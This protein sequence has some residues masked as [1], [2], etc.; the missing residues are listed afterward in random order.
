MP[1]ILILQIQV[2]LVNALASCFLTYLKSNVYLLLINL[3]NLI[4]HYN[5]SGYKKADDKCFNIYFEKSSKLG[6]FKIAD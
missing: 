1:L 6:Q 3:H 2:F 4:V 5:C